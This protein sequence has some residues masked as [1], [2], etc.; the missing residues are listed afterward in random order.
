M[1]GTSNVRSLLTPRFERSSAAIAGLDGIRAIAIVLVLFRHGVRPFL[2]EEGRLFTILG[3]D[4]ATPLLN[5]WMGVDL[6]FVLSGF[7][8]AGSLMRHTRE[9][10]RLPELRPYLLRR[11]LRI[12][13][14]YY[15]VL[16][17]AVLEIIPHYEVSP[18]RLGARIGYH[19]LFLQDYLP[20]DIVVAFWSLGVEEKFYLT[21]PVIW[22]GVVM[23]PSLRLRCAAIGTL[24][25]AAPVFRYLTAVGGGDMSSY[26]SF[27]FVFRSPFHVSIDSLYIGVLAALVY[28]NRARFT[29]TRERRSLDRLF[30]AGA[31]LVAALA[32][33]G[34][35]LTTPLTMFDVVV[36][37]LALGA[38]FGA[39]VLAVALGGGPLGWLERRGPFVVSK[40]SY[41]LYLLHMLFI[42]GLVLWVQSWGITA[43]LSPLIQ[44]VVFLGPYLAVAA[45]AALVVYTVVEQPFLALKDRIG[46]SAAASETRLS[47]VVP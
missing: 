30:L 10:S 39:M 40:L 14:A 2:D 26:D 28:S 45:G 7:L 29:W 37:P 34:E 46:R 42:P 11:I 13:P 27:F 33:P 18:D 44:F 9:G 22:A 24:I 6:F 31:L 3:W 19:M 12:V 32:V 15:F 43:G 4:V 36:Q 35:M 38:G 47:G 16:F 25:L 23:L 21:A 17:L 41:S 8:I 5:G 20:S 1:S